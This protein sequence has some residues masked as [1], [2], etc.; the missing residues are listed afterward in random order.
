MYTWLII[1]IIVIAMIRNS[2]SNSNNRNS[3]LPGVWPRATD[4]LLC[5]STPTLTNC[6]IASEA[7]Q[8]NQSYKVRAYDDRA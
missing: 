3:S 1:I 2:N 8:G 4:V 5:G 7:V 6:L